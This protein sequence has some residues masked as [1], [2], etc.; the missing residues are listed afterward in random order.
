M[1][2]AGVSTTG[3][4]GSGA[5]VAGTRVDGGKVE[6]A[7]DAGRLAAAGTLGMGRAGARPLVAVATGVDQ[8]RTSGV[9]KGVMD[10]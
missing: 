2:G 5:A 1:S 9:G 4:A 10:A 6:E 3:D 8:E 7:T